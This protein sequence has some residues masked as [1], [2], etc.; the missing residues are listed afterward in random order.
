[1]ESVFRGNSNEGSNPSLSASRLPAAFHERM[2]ASPRIVTLLRTVAIKVPERGSFRIARAIPRTTGIGHMKAVVRIA[3]V[4]LPSEIWRLE[5][6]DPV[7][8]L[9]VSKNPPILRNFW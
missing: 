4:A 6:P 3:P 9:T 8:A 5:T 1:M 2:A 7:Q